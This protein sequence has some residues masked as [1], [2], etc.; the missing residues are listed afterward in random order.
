MNR[1][2]EMPCS[3]RYAAFGALDRR[4]GRPAPV[5]VLR[6]TDAL[7]ASLGGAQAGDQSGIHSVAVV[8]ARSTSGTGSTPSPGPVGTRRCPSSSTNGAVRS[9]RK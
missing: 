8:T 6:G 3:Y 5:I 9:V 1:Y 7:V 4:A 2:D